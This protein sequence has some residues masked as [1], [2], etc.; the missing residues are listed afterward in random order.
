MSATSPVAEGAVLSRRALNR[1][2]LERQ[3]LLRRVRLPA[4]DVIERLVGMQ[5][6]VPGDPYTALWSRIEGFEPAELSTLLAE[7]RVVRGVALLRTTIHLVTTRDLLAIRA[8]MQPVL[9]RQFGYSSFRRSLEGI[10]LDE[11]VAAGRRLLEERPHTAGEIGKRLRE[12]WPDRDATSLAY[13]IRYL[14]P[15]LQ[16]PPRGLWGRGGG[17]VLDTPE[18]WLGQGLNENASIDDLVL[19]YLAAFGPATW[20]DAQ[21]WSWIP[22]MRTVFERLRPRL[23]TFRDEAGRELLDVPDGPLPDPATPAPVRFLP[24]Y[25]NIVLSHDDRSRMGAPKL[26]EPIWLRGT[27]LVDGFVRGTW[28]LDVKSMVAGLRIRVFRPLDAAE[29]SGVSDEAERLAAFLAPDVRSRE[30]RIGEDA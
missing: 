28:R 3:L 12:R 16:P 5:A 6:Q 1:A 19:R 13:A 25:D 7:R 17:A 22:G 23:R 24:E 9:E 4:I 29:T 21:T 10:E 14:V 30:I 15:L 20:K 8:L 18:H 11:V 26:T 2:I 27:L